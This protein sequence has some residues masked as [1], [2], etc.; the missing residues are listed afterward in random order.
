MRRGLRVVV[1]G[2]IV[3]AAIATFWPRPSVSPNVHLDN[4]HRVARASIALRREVE[5]RT[6]RTDTV[7]ESF[8]RTAQRA[9]SSVHVL[10]TH[11]DSARQALADSGA[12]LE[13]M[14][15]RL[16]KLVVASNGLRASHLA[17]RDT[18]NAVIVHFL[19]EREAM[20]R[21]V[22]AQDS[23]IRYQQEGIVAMQK[24]TRV[25]ILK[26]LSIGA[27]VGAVTVLVLL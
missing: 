20:Q 7:R 6:A 3:C 8:T 2:L 16:D 9:D 24:A 21:L 14:R 25:K 13:Q 12:S 27:V 26:T 22:M 19:R 1:Y 11:L 18:A 15:N 17:F 4:A 5:R 23:I 10:D